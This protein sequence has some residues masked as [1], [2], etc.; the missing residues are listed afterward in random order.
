MASD[1]IFDKLDTLH[2]EMES[3]FYSL[4][5]PKHPFH[6]LAN[7]RWSPLTDMYEMDGNIVIKI[8]IPGVENE[9]ISLTLEDKQ[10][11]VRGTR[12]N[13]HQRSGVIYHQ[14]E[15]NYGE[16]ERILILPQAIEAE[17]ISAKLEEG[18]LYI[19]IKK[20]RKDESVG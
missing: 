12:T 20:Y 17:Q 16:F 6:L 11:V 7:K 15:I 3:L 8:E 14:M 18:F 13:P 5:N 9:D 2:W 19:K 10:L 4:F 1:N